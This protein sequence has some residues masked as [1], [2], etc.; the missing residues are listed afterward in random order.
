MTDEMDPD[1]EKIMSDNNSMLEHS[2]LRTEYRPHNESNCITLLWDNLM[3][4]GGEITYITL[5]KV[6]EF[7]KAKDKKNFT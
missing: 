7:R 5:E 1:I 4:K 3:E 2:I 6:F